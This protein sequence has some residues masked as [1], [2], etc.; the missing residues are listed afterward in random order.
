LE[1]YLLSVDEKSLLG[2]DLS[3]KQSERALL[4]IDEKVD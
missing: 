4:P 3:N 1:N 2:T